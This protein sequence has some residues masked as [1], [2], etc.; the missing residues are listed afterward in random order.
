MR[1]G[2]ID[3]DW[4]LEVRLALL[5]LGLGFYE[6]GLLP[7]STTIQVIGLLSPA[8]RLPRLSD[9]LHV[10]TPQERADEL[11]HSLFIGFVS[12]RSES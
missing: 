1:L 10:S 12:T 6:S 4:V 7:L 3:R 2:G 11:A 9:T 8:D 5:F